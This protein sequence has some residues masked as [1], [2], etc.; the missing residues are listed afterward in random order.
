MIGHHFGRAIAI[1][2]SVAITACV[3]GVD[4]QPARGDDQDD[5]MDAVILAVAYSDIGTVPNEFDAGDV[6]IAKLV[7]ENGD[8]VPSAGDIIRMGHYPIVFA[9]ETFPDDFGT[10]QDDEHEVTRAA[11]HNATF[12]SVYSDAGQHDW[13]AQSSL[14]RYWEGP[15]SS[16]INDIGAERIHLDPKS[17]SRPAD[18]IYDWRPDTP[19]DPFIDVDIYFT[20]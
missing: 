4:T 16:Y 19:D 12:V 15:T 1:A 2:T 9:P 11:S 14:E 17:P 18:A 13:L 10:W 5:G 3:L 20:S 7:D 8:G 6:L